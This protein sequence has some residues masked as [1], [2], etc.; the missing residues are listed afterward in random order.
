MVEPGF[1]EFD[2]LWKSDGVD[3]VEHAADEA[4]KIL[5]T[6][7]G[8]PPN[9]ICVIAHGRITAGFLRCLGISPHA[10]P[11]GGIIAAVVRAVSSESDLVA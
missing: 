5:Q 6:I 3:T 1:T 9:F 10:T 7:W 4:E 8:D 2:E 11:T